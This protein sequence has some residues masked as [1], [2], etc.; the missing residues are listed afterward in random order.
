MSRSG[1][2]RSRGDS[3]VL[4]PCRPPWQPGSWIV[5]TA[6][7]LAALDLSSVTIPAGVFFPFAVTIQFRLDPRDGALV[8]TGNPSSD[9]AAC[10]GYTG[11]EIIVYTAE[12]DIN[13][14]AVQARLVAVPN[15]ASLM[16]LGVSLAGGAAVVALR[17]RLSA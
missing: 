13:S 16:L 1:G 11:S 10:G 14:L 9:P 17:R 15:P 4:S 8:C 3:L 12:N 5:F 7:V 6:L 2:A